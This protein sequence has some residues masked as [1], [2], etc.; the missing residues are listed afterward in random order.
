M[1]LLLS[2]LRYQ[3]AQLRSSQRVRYRGVDF[4][5]RGTAVANLATT[6]A[7]RSCSTRAPEAQLSELATAKGLASALRFLDAVEP[8]D[9]TE[10]L[11]KAGIDACVAQLA[12][13]DALRLQVEM[14]A[15]LELGVNSYS[16]CLVLSR[17]D[18]QGK[19][20][21]QRSQFF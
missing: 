12:R 20:R 1:R 8:A 5:Q 17:L 9:R 4:G 18:I 6:A 16:K 15:Q 10:E 3:A 19:V 14:A 2:P 21:G 11:Y 13:R 7:V